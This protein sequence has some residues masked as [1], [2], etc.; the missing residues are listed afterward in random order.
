LC[1]IKY[2]YK[3]VSDNPI[4]RKDDSEIE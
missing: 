1:Y 2:G 3:L 4:T